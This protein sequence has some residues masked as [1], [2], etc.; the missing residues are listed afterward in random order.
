[1]RKCYW[2]AV[3]VMC[4]PV[5]ARAQTIPELARTKPANPIVRGVLRDVKSAPLETLSNE[6]SLILVGRLI[7]V[8]SY[9][10]PDKMNVLTDYT[11]VPDRII[12][13][14]LP[15]T[16]SAPGPGA[17][18]TVTVYGGDVTIDGV[19]VSAVDHNSELPKSGQRYLLFL[20][21]FGS[22][23]ARYQPH[24]EAVFEIE[25]DKLRTLLRR[26]D[27]PNAYSDV[28]DKGLAGAVL[29]IARA[30]R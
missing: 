22:G 19:T 1:M 27:T 9:L 6:A 21:P 20:D 10:T 14:Q 2:L 17:A 28:I 7:R 15:L 18:P 12:A 5:D 29:E 30:R 16:Q 11:I 25:N 24:R 13:G 3:L 23:A 26:A 4:A 8:K